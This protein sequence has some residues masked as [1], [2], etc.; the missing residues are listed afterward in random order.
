MLVRA[1]VQAVGGDAA[2][3]TPSKGKGKKKAKQDAA[4]DLSLGHL[5]VSRFSK[6]LYLFFV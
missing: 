1:D 6:V 5:D 3:E 4:A 2:S